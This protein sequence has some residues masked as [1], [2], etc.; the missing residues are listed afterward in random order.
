MKPI[1]YDRANQGAIADIRLNIIDDNWYLLDE[2]TLF[3]LV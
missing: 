2:A 1:F 3:D